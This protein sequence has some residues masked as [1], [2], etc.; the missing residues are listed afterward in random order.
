MDASVISIIPWD[1]IQDEMQPSFPMD[2]DKALLE[3]I[4]TT[5]SE[6]R[7]ILNSLNA[8]LKL[9][10]TQKLTSFEE[11]TTKK[12][13][14]QENKSSTRTETFEQ[15]DLNSLSVSQNQQITD[16]SNSPFIANPNQINARM[17][18]S[19]ATALYQEV[20]LLNKY[21]KYASNRKG[22]TPYL[23][24]MQVS[25][26][27]MADDARYDAYSTISF[28]PDRFSGITENTISSPKNSDKTPFVVPLLVSE[29]LEKAS[30]SRNNNDIL[31]MAMALQATFN[32]VGVETGFDKTLQDMLKLS[33]TDYNSLMTV[34]R[35]SDNSIRVRF[36]AMQT[37]SE[38]GETKVRVMVPRTHYVNLLLMVPGTPPENNNLVAVTRTTVVH[39]ETG[40]PLEGKDQ[41]DIVKGARKTFKKY[42][43]E[44]PYRINKHPN[45]A[46]D[47]VTMAIDVQTNRWSK[48]SDHFKKLCES[49][50]NATDKKNPFCIKTSEGLRE[51][52]WVDLVDLWVG[53]QYSY[54]FFEVPEPPQKQDKEMR[55][56]EANLAFYAFDDRSKTTVQIAGAQN[57]K[58]A[59]LDP[60]LKIRINSNE[61]SFPAYGVNVT[62]KGSCEIIF[63]SFAKD[64]GLQRNSLKLK[65]NSKDQLHKILYTTSPLPQPKQPLTAATSMQN[66]SI[67]KGVGILQV[68]FT[69][70]GK[71]SI[72]RIQNAAID[73]SYMVKNGFSPITQLN[74][75]R[76]IPGNGLYNIPLSNMEQ[77]SP[78]ILSAGT[79][80]KNKIPSQTSTIIVEPRN[81]TIKKK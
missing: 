2:A 26:T 27:P 31:Q 42:G 5:L 38:Y 77:G 22:Y 1:E 41:A 11:T 12:T 6:E 73:S 80:N 28:F 78:V 57:L 62:G 55:L 46:I 15:P 25:L 13:G 37:A 24:R 71:N 21:V 7:K 68:S 52:I 74:G 43:I 61:Y 47:F 64:T 69:G 56:P 33:G 65:L 9:A 49:L 35:I 20:R 51:Q 4:P 53:G 58:T 39:N 14:E 45:L 48:F 23:V 70:V 34:G 18:H 16:Q 3:A 75:W 66:I 44:S 79:N 10:L 30:F 40:V 17:R 32:S 19:A 36:G 54:T 63:P 67:T 76:T 50:D 60:V 59:E 72:M 8:Y 29:D 81:F